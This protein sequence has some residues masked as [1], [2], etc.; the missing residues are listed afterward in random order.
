MSR[1]GPS[2]RRRIRLEDH[3]VPLVPVEPNPKVVDLGFHPLADTFLPESLQYGPEESYPLQ[4]GSCQEC[5]HVF[6]LYSVS[7][8]DRYQK[9]DYSYDSSNSK[10]AILHFKDFSDSVLR[11]I[12]P[13]PDALIVDIGSNVGTLLGHFKDSGHA[14]VPRHGAVREH[15]RT[16]R[17]RRASRRCVSFSAPPR[18]RA[19]RCAGGSKF[20]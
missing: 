11:N 19:S 15:R 12:S 16:L 20:C 4:L 6:T 14:N 13:A 18:P 2:P 1:P 17:S 5:G 8:E 7:P 10:V 3:E 9:Q